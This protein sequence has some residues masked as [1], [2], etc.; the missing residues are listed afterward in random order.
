MSNVVL[1]HKYRFTSSSGTPTTINVNSLLGAAGTMCTVANT[2]VSTFFESVRV[3]R[4]QIWTPPAAQ[5][6]FATCSLEW[7][8][9]TSANNL[10]VSDTSISTATPAYISSRPPR[11]SLAAFWQK[12]AAL[13]LFQLTAPSGSIIDV[14]LELI[15]SDDETTPAT[16]AVASGTLGIVYYLALDSANGTHIYTPVSLV[17]TF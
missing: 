6:S 5:G 7:F 13:N 8:G 16:T 14:D 3:G 9:G 10:E 4:V 2:T 17:T 15:M 11:L 1:S 12:P